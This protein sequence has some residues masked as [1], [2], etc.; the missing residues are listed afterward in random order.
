LTG[1]TPGAERLFFGEADHNNELPDQTR[2]VRRGAYKLCFDRAS[3]AAELFDLGRDPA[4]H[5][6]LAGEQPRRVEEL[7]E[8]LAAFEQGG[9]QG[10]ALDQP[11]TP[12]ELRRLE[13]L[14]Y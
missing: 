2:M 1:N 11:L 5:K 12:E 13:A 10:E 14:G 6:D 4:E 7:L 8:A 3:E 9:I